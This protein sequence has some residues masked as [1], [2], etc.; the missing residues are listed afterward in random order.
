MRLMV[1]ATEALA[2]DTKRCARR[3]EQLTFDIVRRKRSLASNAFICSRERSYTNDMLM[4]AAC[5]ING[6][7]PVS[8]TERGK[9]HEEE[10]IG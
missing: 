4:L 2:R 1:R 5:G 6:G 8:K 3:H 7:T 10:A 9:D